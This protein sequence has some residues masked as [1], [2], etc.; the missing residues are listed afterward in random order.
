MSSVLTVR[1]L[2]TGYKK[3]SHVQKVSHEISLDVNEGSLTCLLGP[4][5]IGKSTL[6]RTIS[7]LQNKIST[8]FQSR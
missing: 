4:N 1:N 3:G 8:G 7:G 6:L 2:V 5:G